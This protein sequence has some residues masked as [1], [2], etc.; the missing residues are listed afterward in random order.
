MANGNEIAPSLYRKKIEDVGDA[1]GVEMTSELRKK[2][3]GR[4]SAQRDVG[5]APRTQP[6]PGDFSFVRIEADDL[7]GGILRGEKRD[8]RAVPAPGVQNG[9]LRAPGGD[10]GQ[11]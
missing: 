11:R 3:L 1:D 4:S 6:R 8:Q 9:P 2:I 10:L 7:A 5:K